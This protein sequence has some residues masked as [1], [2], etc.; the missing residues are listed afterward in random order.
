M[1]MRV[2]AEQERNH[3]QVFST[4]PV[5]NVL[6]EMKEIVESTKME[7]GVSSLVSKWDE[8]ALRTYSRDQQVDVTDR[9]LRDFKLTEQQKKV[10]EDMRRQKPLPL[11][12][13]KELLQKG[14]PLP[15][16]EPWLSMPNSGTW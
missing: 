10:I 1:N 4:A 12:K 2:K 14:E 7:A 8:V 5:D 16:S 15:K 11:D 6:A 13:A 3:L 9:L